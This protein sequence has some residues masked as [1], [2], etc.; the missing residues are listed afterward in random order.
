[1]SLKARILN[2]LKGWRF[3]GTPNQGEALPHWRCNYWSL[4]T[5][6]AGQVSLHDPRYGN[7]REFQVYTGMVGSEELTFAYAEVSNG[8]FAVF[9]RTT[10]AG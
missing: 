3:S 10:A 7:L 1:M 5:Q 6:P 8:V 2:R 9:E 4:C